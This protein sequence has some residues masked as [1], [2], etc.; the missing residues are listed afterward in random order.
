LIYQKRRKA[1]K[2]KQMTQE[3]TIKSLLSRT[4]LIS[5]PFSF[6]QVRKGIDGFYFI[7]KY[8]GIHWVSEKR[9]NKRVEAHLEGFMEN[10]RKFY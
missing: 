1:L 7:S 10:N 4:K 2:T 6:I 8:T 9:W 3:Q 5:Q